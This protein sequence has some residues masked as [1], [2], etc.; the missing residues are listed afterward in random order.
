MELRG[1]S[2][3]VT[4]TR[5]VIMETIILQNL[6]VK[7]IVAIENVSEVSL[8]PCESH[9]PKI[10]LRPSGNQTLDHIRQVTYE[11]SFRNWKRITLSCVPFKP[12][13]P[14][15]LIQLVKIAHSFL[16]VMSKLFHPIIFSW[17]RWF[18]I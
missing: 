10:V 15:K 13:R 12:K 6:T 16:Y 8:N 14:V 9:D 1:S 3:M 18:Y 4:A 7:K 2:N 5:I 17:S 11:H